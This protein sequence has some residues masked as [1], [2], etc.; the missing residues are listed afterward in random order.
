[1]CWH[2]YRDADTLKNASWSP[3]KNQHEETST[4]MLEGD[5]H[6]RN[7]IYRMPSR[8]TKCHLSGSIS[9][10]D[11]FPSI[12]TAAV[13][14]CCFFLC[15]WLNRTPAPP[16]TSLDKWGFLSIL[17]IVG[18]ETQEYLD[19][20]KL[21]LYI[22]WEPLPCVGMAADLSCANSG[23][24][25]ESE[26]QG[27]KKENWMWMSITSTR[28]A[29][30]LHLSLRIGGY[31][32]MEAWH[33]MQGTPRAWLAT[34]FLLESWKHLLPQGLCTCWSGFLVICT[35]HTLHSRLGSTESPQRGLSGPSYPPL[36]TP[37]SHFI[38]WISSYSNGRILHSFI[39]FLFTYLMPSPRM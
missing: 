33:S 29:H 39:W 32:I 18:K 11:E 28:A 13:D 14:S 7:I 9:S 5:T 3:A 4:Y 21:S 22:F 34:S 38:F 31:T 24:E 15:S 6:G 1:M 16:A 12:S 10:E 36:C 37:F 17:K 23:R 20:Q 2:V 25:V 27:T 19:L 26:P 8:H 30:L 35:V